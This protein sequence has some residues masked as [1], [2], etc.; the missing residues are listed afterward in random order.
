[1]PYTYLIT[2]V[3]S[4]LKYYGV[5]YAKNAK[6]EDLWTTYFTS[7][8]QIK[9]M[10]AESGKDS[11]VTEIR[12]IFDTAEQAIAWETRV[13]TRLGIP[14]NKSYI[15]KCKNHPLSQIDKE[16]LMLIKYGVR[17]SFHHPDMMKKAK[18]SLMDNY[19]VEHPIHSSILRE[20][21][22][23]TLN[24]RYGVDYSWQIPGVFEKSKTTR[25]ER[26]G[27]EFSMQSSELV[28]QSKNTQIEKF[29]DWKIRTSEVQEKVK[30][31]NM[32]KYGTD[33][34]FK[35][36]GLVKEIMIE[37]Y[38]V[39]NWFQTQEGKRAITDSW[40]KRIPMICPHCGKES[41]AFSNMKRWHFDNCKKNIDE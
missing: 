22:Q 12:K 41:K 7:S 10:I 4:G 38:G 27:V 30:K 18:K 6:P 29:G 5:R 21:T 1:M 39:E 40:I 33:N 31:T 24:E 23:N 17:H 9:L 25:M 3:P 19:G 16:E 8:E 37:K 36:P 20:K 28:E 35:V 13:L 11:F 14:Y 34:P 15:N 2:H 26:L 32:E